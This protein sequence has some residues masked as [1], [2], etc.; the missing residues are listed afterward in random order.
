MMFSISEYLTAQF[1]KWEWRGRGWKL[2]DHPVGLEPE[3]IPF[4]GHIN[5]SLTQIDTGQRPRFFPKLQEYLGLYKK[6]V[7]LDNRDEVFNELDELYPINAYKLDSHNE[8]VEYIVN[9]S[10]DLKIPFDNI[11]QLILSLVSNNGILGFEI[12]GTSDSI[13]IQF[14]SS[15]PNRDQ[16]KSKIEAFAPGVNVSIKIDSL[17]NS[18]DINK[19]LFV[20]DMALQ[21][22]FMC[23]LRTWN[24]FDPDPLLSTIV[25]LEA[26]KEGEFGMIQILFSKVLNPW[27][28]SMYRAVTDGKGGSFFED[29]PQIFT[30]AK[31]KLSSPLIATVIRCI[32]QGNTEKGSFDIADS[33]NKC[34]NVLNRIGSNSLIPLSDGEISCDLEDI[35]FRRS[36]RIG[37]LLN[38]MELASIVHIP[39]KSIL[40]RKLRK[41]TGKTKKAPNTVIGNQFVLGTNSHLGEDSEI[42]LT[43]EQRLRHMH[44]IGVTGTGKSTLLMNLIH[45]DLIEGKGIAVLDPHGDLIDA[46]ISHIPNNRLEDIILIDPSDVNYPVGFN[47]IF[48][49]DDAEKIILSSDLVSIF[50]RFATSWGDQMTSVLSNAIIGILEHEEGGTF[51]DLKRFLIEPSFRNSFLLNVKDPNVIYYW[52]H[53]F[54]LIRQNSIAPILTRLDTFLRPR[55]IRN[56]M[57]QKK[58]INFHDVVNSKKILLVKLS[59][60]LIGE[61]NSY[62]LGTLIVAK[63]HQAI[64]SRQSIDVK[65]RKPFFMYIDE[66][67][68]FITPSMAS[69]LSGARKYGLGLI[70]AHQDLDQLYSKDTE[71]ANSVLSNP[72]TRICFRCGDKDSTKLENGFSSFDSTDLQNL[73]IGHTIVRVDKKEHDFNMSFV[74]LSRVDNS[75][76][77]NNLE[78]I[79]NNTRTHYAKP[80]NEIEELLL[81]SF[82]VK[83][84][85][86][87]KKTSVKRDIV[88][89]IVDDVN[90]VPKFENTT[91]LTTPQ[92]NTVIEP[93]IDI[94]SKEIERENLKEHRLIQNYIKKIGEERNFKS[95]IEDPVND[96]KGRVDV[97]LI[98]NDL[99]IA[100]E[101]SVSNTALY[102]VQNINK[103]LLAQF[104][105]VFMISNNSKHLNDIRILAVESIEVKFHSQIFFV[106]KDEFE[107]SLDLVLLNSMKNEE[108]RVKGYRVKLNYSQSKDVNSQND[109]IKNIILGS[110]RRKE[111]E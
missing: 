14:V 55:I 75:I 7:T 36:R 9:F 77:Q 90:E 65:F 42:S 111:I 96:N 60:G 102:E 33:L 53:E 80:V 28:E 88:T 32:G 27:A 34:L 52:K 78:C 100:C 110:I 20:I 17:R 70:L 11:E 104:N 16:F 54:P 31:E 23:P 19:D 40:S 93:P 73:N 6:P 1:Y 101:V 39:D 3:F 92:S 22:E 83:N 67:Q 2:F 107:S 69:I 95:V 38:S 57:A 18:M 35:Y 4:F 86:F 91:N 97:S 72:A 25:S 63:I 103:C 62:I 46:I 58:G 56:M 41:Y 81:K 76:F 59:Q 30:L 15:N 89:Q 47:L 68:N 66:F 87:E 50:R 48:A 37:M 64:Q 43:D 84:P 94:I 109:A 108:V 24:K 98:R 45:E 29:A 79:L 49:E 85:S 99:K 10:K 74:P 12:I 51:I 105:M 21:D 82:E 5:P 13:N 106:L 71:L 8:V 26:L 61:E 44:I